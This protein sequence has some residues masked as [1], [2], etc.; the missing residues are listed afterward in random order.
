MHYRPIKTTIEDLLDEFDEKSFSFAVGKI[1]LA[2]AR[3]NVDLARESL[4]EFLQQACSTDAITL[5]SPITLLML[6]VR[7]TNNLEANGYLTVRSL[8][9]ASDDELRCVPDLAESSLR[10]IREVLGETHVAPVSK[11]SRLLYNTNIHG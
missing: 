7:M 8:V 2:I 1:R 11:L 3:G 6:P 4:E 10:K 5:D 9:K